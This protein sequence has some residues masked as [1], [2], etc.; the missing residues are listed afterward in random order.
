MRQKIVAGNWKMNKDF[1]EVKQLMDELPSKM[2]KNEVSKI[3][4]PPF[5]FLNEVA[6]AGKNA[7]IKTG[8]QNCSEHDKGAYT[9]EVSAAMIASCGAEY[10][11][12]GHSER[13]QYF[14]ETNAQL[15][16]KIIRC[17]ENNLIPVFCVGEKLE[18]RRSEIHF[19]VVEQQVAE[20]FEKFSAGDLSKLIIAYEPVW[21]IGTG[22]T[23]SPAQAQ[24]MHAFIRTLVKKLK[25]DKLAAQ[26]PLLYGGSCN[27]QN[28]KELFSCADVDGGLIGGASLKAEDFA[29]IAKSFSH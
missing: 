3:V 11:L 22:E 7:G 14:S 23:A 8:A 5:P 18:E 27:P 13:R 19:K 24:Q 26:M 10:C 4:F 25:G 6:S 15:T 1:S 16:N 2:P 28:A 29:Q 9:G 20:V 21:A 17:F 12:V